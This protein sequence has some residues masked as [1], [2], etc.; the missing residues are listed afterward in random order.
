MA[1]EKVKNTFYFTGNELL[2]MLAMDLCQESYSFYTQR[3]G[4]V[5]KLIYE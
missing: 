1:I 4:A 3:N 2:P 5:E